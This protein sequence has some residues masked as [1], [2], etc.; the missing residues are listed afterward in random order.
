M[1]RSSKSNQ[2]RE[3][4]VFIVILSSLQPQGFCTRI[5]KRRSDSLAFAASKHKNLKC[6]KNIAIPI[7]DSDESIKRL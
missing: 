3:C 7:G 1:A 2:Q 6:S 5:G 4:V